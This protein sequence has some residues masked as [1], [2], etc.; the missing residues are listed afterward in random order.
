MITF[1]TGNANKLKEV[2]Q[3]LEGYEVGSH[4]LDLPELQGSYAE[5]VAHKV[6]SA[7]EAVNGPV[8]VDDTALEFDAFEKELPGPYIKWFLEGLGAEKLPRMLDGFSNKGA[9]A[10]SCVGYCEGPGKEPHIFIG[11]THGKIVEVRGP[12]NFG[13]D[14]I[15]EPDG[16]K[17]TYAEMEKV[18]KN[19]I[20][21]R[22]KAFDQFKAFLKNN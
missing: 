13:W 20:S 3:I 4:K 1:V 2:Q 12:Q 22:G 15:F 11:K 18:E 10:V 9:N 6:T 19:K 17:Q 7:A 21:H 14:C 16:F 5:I 8:V